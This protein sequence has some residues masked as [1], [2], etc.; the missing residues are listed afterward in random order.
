[1]YGYLR[2]PAR[3]ALPPSRARFLRRGLPAALVAALALPGL[4]GAATAAGGA[5]AAGSATKQPAS[6]TVEQC[7][8]GAE[9]ALHSATFVG[10][11]TA[12]PGTVHMLMRIDVLERTPGE[13][14][15]RAVTAPGLGV[16]RSAA[17]GVK[18]F[19][20]LKQVT[21]LSAPAVYRAAIRFRW[22]GAKNRPLKTLEL[23]TPRC[24]QRPL[25]AGEATTSA[26]AP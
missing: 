18:D 21:D 13:L 4:A 2:R 7:L 6:A 3:G 1:M 14:A 24:V 12:V 5:T 19:K 20:Y 8:S 16:W 23:F 25:P 10:E 11:M 9:Q 17:N 22:L 15:F 26:E